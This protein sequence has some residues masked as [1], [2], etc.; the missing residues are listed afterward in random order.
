MSHFMKKIVWPC[1]LTIGTLFL[2][3]F[4]STD[5]LYWVVIPC[6]FALWCWV[7]YQTQ[8]ADL[9]EQNTDNNSHIESI[10]RYLHA[11][12]NCTEQ[13]VKDFIA[14]LEQVKTVVSDAVKTLSDSFNGMHQLSVTQSDAMHS[15]VNNLDGRS[16]DGESK[17]I[18]FQHL[19]FSFSKIS[20]LIFNSLKN[21]I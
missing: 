21:M 4:F 17:S 3:L 15:L 11:L 10:D 8:K 2:P 7:L 1:L 6:L 19:F 14:E 9:L 20:W 13:E 5:T 16:A 18:N 12:H